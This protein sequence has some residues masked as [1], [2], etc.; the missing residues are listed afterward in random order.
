[1]FVDCTLTRLLRFAVPW[2][3]CPGLTLL[4][5]AS[6]S[7]RRSSHGSDLETLAHH[8]FQAPTYDDLRLS[9]DG[10]HMAI[11]QYHKDHRFIRTLNYETGKAVIE[12]SSDV[13]PRSVY[14]L[15]LNTGGMAPVLA[16]RKWIDS[17]FSE[18]ASAATRR[19]PGPPSSPRSIDVQ[20]DMR[21]S[22]TG[23]NR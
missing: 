4:L 13:Q 10:S 8:F 20:L 7:A 18:E 3:V 1:M 17:R 12:V 21:E 23:Y 11:V 9:P 5:G 19:S 15:N 14:I 2:F 16:S 6:V 22:T